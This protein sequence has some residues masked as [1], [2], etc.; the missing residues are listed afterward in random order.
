MVDLLF[1]R[2]LIVCVTLQLILSI[3]K[4]RDPNLLLLLLVV[5]GVCVQISRQQGNLRLTLLSLYLTFST[6]AVGLGFKHLFL[7]LLVE[8]VDCAIAVFGFGFLMVV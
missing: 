1:L 4:L 8:L 3:G 6:M 7:L 5:A 2:H